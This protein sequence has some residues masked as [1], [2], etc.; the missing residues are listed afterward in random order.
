M[1][2]SNAPKGSWQALENLCSTAPNKA[3]VIVTNIG[4]RH[5]ERSKAGDF[6]VFYL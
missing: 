5:G 3:A 6:F 1:Y 4:G 2:F